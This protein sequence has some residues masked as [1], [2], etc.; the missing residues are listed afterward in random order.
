MKLPLIPKPLGRLAARLPQYPHSLALAAALNLGL[1]GLFSD[2]EMQ[3]VLGK[4]VRLNIQDA[5][6]RLTIRIGANGCTPCAD[7]VVPDATISAA[8]REFA[9]LA[10]RKEDPDTLF[11]DRRLRIEG[12]TE[13]GLI[14]KN[15]LDRVEPPLPASLLESVRQLVE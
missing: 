6:V 9:L 2:H 11:F 12:D 5:G 8:A 1:R 10:L 7:N 15:A 3:R 4:V 13:L 14:V